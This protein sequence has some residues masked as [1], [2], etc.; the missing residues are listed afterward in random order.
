MAN[1]LTSDVDASVRQCIRIIQAG[2]D[3]V[4]FTVPSIADIKSFG[5]IKSALRKQGYRTPLIADVHFNAEIAIAVSDFAD[6]VRVNPGNFGSPDKLTDLIQKCRKN[7]T[8]LRIGV[9]HGSLSERMMKK[10]GDTPEGMV[11]SAMEFL[12]ICRDQQ[13]DQV[14]VSMKAS[15]VRVMVYANRL[16]ADVM[17]NEG[18]NYPLHLGVTEAGEGEDGRIKSAV[19]ISTLLAD[20]I[21]DT[22]RVS[23]TEEPEI[24][25]P[26]ARKLVALVNNISVDESWPE[27]EEGGN[28]YSFTRRKTR[29]TR[30]I[31]GSQPPIVIGSDKVTGDVHFIHASFTGVH[32]SLIKNLNED[33]SSVLVYKPEK[34]NVQAELR[35]LCHT[36]KKGHCD[37][38]VIF[39]LDLNEENDEAFMLK[40][41]S[42]LGGAFIDGF[43]DGIWLTKQFEIT[44]GI[45]QSVALGILQAC[46]ARISKT[47]Y[48]SCPSCGRT[49]FNLMDTLSRI[50][51]ETSH[52][53]GLKIGVM[54]CIVNGPGEMADADYGYV[55]A[56]KGKITLYKAK[57]VVKK[58]IPEEEAVQELVA[59]IKQNG[60]WVEPD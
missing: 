13:F 51:A 23:L 52:L 22:I 16:I 56:G 7:G 35:W 24:E 48:I 15:N 46:R 4:R 31:G 57:E 33:K 47:E 21:G 26:V 10:Y 18:M 59:L 38:P 17:K 45:C 9:N 40:S 39:R 1:T 49:H 44:P 27:M 30:N 6:K 14:V 37:A 19:G 34:S 53:K 42:W 43:G 58:G 41:S 54:G 60:D 36:L 55:G 32:E 25:I 50:K 8:A 2:S 3:Y 12:R 5:E 29:L 20:G 28:R 11:E